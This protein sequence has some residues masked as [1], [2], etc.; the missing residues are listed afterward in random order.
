MEV[1]LWKNQTIYRENGQNIPVR[2][3]NTQKSNFSIINS[4]LAWM[5]LI[6]VSINERTFE[7]G[8]LK[9]V[10][11]S[12]ISCLNHFPLILASFTN[13]KW[14]INQLCTLFEIFIFC[15]K[16]Q[17][18]FPE[19]IVDFWGEKL[20]N[21]L[22]FWTFFENFDFTRKIVW[23]IR[24]KVGVLSILNFWFKIWLLEYVVYI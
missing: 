5:V 6:K 15:P 2:A 4:N 17:L 22:W 12:S 16:I 11:Y 14:L 20:V 3:K 24:E 7:I 21:M 18:W 8:S 10:V 1:H 9:Y 19:K 13:F 23:K